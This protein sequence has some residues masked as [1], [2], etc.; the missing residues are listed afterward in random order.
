MAISRSAPLPY[1]QLAIVM[2]SDSHSQDWSKLYCEMKPGKQGRIYHLKKLNWEEKQL[3]MTT[4]FIQ[5]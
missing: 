2:Y 5:I 1:T 4:G 3:Y